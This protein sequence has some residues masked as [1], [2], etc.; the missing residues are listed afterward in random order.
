VSQD[1]KQPSINIL[2]I[3][4]ALARFHRA[5][6]EDTSNARRLRC[7]SEFIR[8]R[9]GQRCVDCHSRRRLA[10]HHI[11]RKSFLKTGR[12][13][14]GNGITLCPDCHRE[15]HA[16][17]NGRPN[18]QLPMD[19]QDGEKLEM[20]ERLYS[21]LATDAKERGI[22]RDD[23]YFIS[24]D[25]LGRFKMFQG[26]DYFTYFPG[27]RVEQAFL[28]WAQN[29]LNT[30]RALACASGFDLP[31]EPFVPGTTYIMLD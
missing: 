8:E 13:E 17:F 22:L 11:C 23:L 10:A 1:T 14:T 2:S 25:I 30:R 21:I 7:W 29:P 16:G 12:F 28:I 18:L 26:F 20:M 31:R 27:C 24:D 3:E 9:D 4:A 5:L 15:V 6:A 19:A